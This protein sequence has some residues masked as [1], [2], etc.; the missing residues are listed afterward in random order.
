MVCLTGSVCGVC[1]VCGVCVCGGGGGVMGLIYTDAFTV[2]LYWVLHQSTPQS[3]PMIDYSEFEQ[4]G[5]ARPV[6]L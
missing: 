6:Q 1:G 2:E 3:P 5:K 4:R